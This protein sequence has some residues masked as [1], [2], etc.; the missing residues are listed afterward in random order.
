MKAFLKF[1]G[2][3]AVLH[4]MF[5]L[6]PH[7]VFAQGYATIRGTVTD[8]TGAIIP[9]AEVTATRASTGLMLKTTT[10]SEG[11]YVFP[12]WRRQSTTYQSTTLAL[13]RTRRKACRLTRTPP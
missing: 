6:T 3:V 1:A 11:T 13:R 5:L 8:S 2:M 10:N 12:R 7:A 9:G 4:I